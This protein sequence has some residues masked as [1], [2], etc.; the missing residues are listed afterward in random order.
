[1]PSDVSVDSLD[2]FAWCVRLSRLLV[3]FRT[4]F[5]SLHFLSFFLSFISKYYLCSVI[6]PP[7]CCRYTLYNTRFDGLLKIV[8][9]SGQCIICQVNVPGLG[10]NLTT[11]YTLAAVT[12]GWGTEKRK[13]ILIF[14][15][16]KIWS[17]SPY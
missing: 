1:M 12:T 10:Y 11:F 9:M 2:L 6:L 14:S 8:T 5:K 15:V 4:H 7:P 17:L 16:F 13:Q 3:G